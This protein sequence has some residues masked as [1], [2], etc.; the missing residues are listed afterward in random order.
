[1]ESHSYFNRNVVMLANLTLAVYIIREPINFSE[2]SQPNKKSKGIK[3]KGD[4]KLPAYI[5]VSALKLIY[6]GFFS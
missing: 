5:E 3:N 2:L 1:M 6:P 4:K